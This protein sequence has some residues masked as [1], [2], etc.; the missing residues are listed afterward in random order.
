MLFSCNEALGHCHPLLPLARAARETGHDVAFLSGPGLREIVEGEGFHF[1]TGGPEFG[2][3]VGEALARHPDAKLATP[4][5]QQEFG[6]RY[7]FSETRVALT[8]QDAMRSA[9]RFAPDLI[10][11]EV[12][13]FVGPLVAAWR[14]IPNAT[15]GVSLVPREEL[16]H[17]AADAVADQWKAAGLPPRGDA[18]LYRSLYLNQLPRSLQR[19]LPTTLCPVHDV[20]PVAYGADE[21]LPDDLHHL[22]QQ[23]PLVYVTFGSIF[24]DPTVLT[25]IGQALAELDVDLLMTVGFDID[26][27]SLDL[28]GP[29]VAVRSFVPQGALLPRCRLVVTHGGAGSVVGALRYGVP[30]LIVPVG[31]DQSE[32]CERVTAAGAGSRIPLQELTRERIQEAVRSMLRDDDMVG[33][34]DALRREI[35]AMP[36]PNQVVPVLEALVPG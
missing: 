13:D 36:T 30:L 20:Q 1:L 5:E 18:G 4:E 31:A 32:N 12:A 11:N 16:L 26:P 29:T 34:A 25:L 6:F 28:D 10:V 9:E 27:S 8:V 15:A 33:I 3:L 2:A 17:M 14:R 22:G 35:L 21:V 19:S 23:R 24:G 7:L